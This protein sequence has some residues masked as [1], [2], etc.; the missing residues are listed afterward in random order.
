L[1]DRLTRDEVR[2]RAGDQCE[3]CLLAQQHS[4][5]ARLQFEH[6]IP[7]KH[8]GGDQLENLALA[9]IDCNLA[10]SSNLTGIDS[11][12]GKIVELF[13]PRMQNWAEHF[14]VVGNRIFGSTP[15]GRATV[16]VLNFNSTG[17]LRV[18]AVTGNNSP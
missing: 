10:K 14:E 4:P 8:G 3:Y 13:N 2:R 15:S 12:T 17:R 18:R 7:R 9:C 5:V 6:I 16:R 1:I 11:E